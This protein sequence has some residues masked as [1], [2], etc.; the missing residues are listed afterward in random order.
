MWTNKG[1]PLKGPPGRPCFAASHFSLH[2]SKHLNGSW[3]WTPQK[4]STK[5]GESLGSRK[6]QREVKAARCGDDW[7]LPEVH[8]G[9]TGRVESLCTVSGV[10][11][12]SEEW[13]RKLCRASRRMAVPHTLRRSLS[14]SDPASQVFR[15]PSR[16]GKACGVRSFCIPNKIVIN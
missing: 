2:C 11:C 12:L 6:R 14:F 13:P 3:P 16:V 7:R 15:G 4:H 8:A 10:R 9:R 1:A 5:S